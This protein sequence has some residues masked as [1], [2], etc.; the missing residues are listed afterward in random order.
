M[1][2]KLPILA[3]FQVASPCDASWDEMKGDDAKRFCGK[4]EK[5]VYNLPLLT[6]DELV[7]LIEATEGK[8]CGRIYARKDGTVL[9]NDCPVGL[10]AKLARARK[11]KMVGAGGA[12]AAL[13]FTAGA[14]ILAASWGGVEIAPPRMV[15]G[16]MMP[17]EQP[18]TPPA[19]PEMLMGDI[20]ITVEPQPQGPPKPE[21]TDIK[22]GKIMIMPDDI[23][24]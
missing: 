14:A 16:E 19:E 8:F 10:T 21:P 24:E 15:A 4:C 11:K 1:N 6:P 2:A 7:D 5:H 23:T 12:I 22:M 18:Q 20:D 17:I 9:T 3:N 13:C